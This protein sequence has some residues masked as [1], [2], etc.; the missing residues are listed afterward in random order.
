MTATMIATLLLRTSLVL[1]LALFAQILARKS[2]AWSNAIGRTALVIALGLMFFKVTPPMAVPALVPISFSMP[3][4]S[5]EAPI[6]ASEEPAPTAS[7][8]PGY[9]SV[10]TDEWP[11]RIWLGGSAFI[12]LWTLIGTIRISRM[13]KKCVRV[14][15]PLLSEIAR[16]TGAAEP[17]VL[18]GDCI[19][20]P[21]VAGL[22]RPTIYVPTGWTNT[23]DASCQSAVLTHEAAHIANGDLLWLWV[24][25]ASL[26][27]L[28]P[29]PFVW[30]VCRRIQ[31]ASEELADATVIRLGLDRKS[32]AAC[33]LDH[34]A[35][36][37]KLAP[38]MSLATVGKKSALAS[39]IEAIM[40]GRIRILKLTRTSSAAVGLTM[41]A[42]MFGA[43]TVFGY[44]AQA[45]G[46]YQRGSYAT[47]V[48]V[49]SK[50]KSVPK[51]NQALL[52]VQESFKP[53]QVVELKVNKN[54]V[55]IPRISGDSDR[56]TLLIKYDA[57]FSDIKTIWPST[58]KVVGMQVQGEGK[59]MGR[60]I[61]AQGSAMPLEI[62]PT[63]F[64]RVQEHMLVDAL[65]LPDSI[66]R[67]FVTKID[68]D[69]GFSIK[70]LPGN[71]KVRLQVSDPNYADFGTENDLLATSSSSAS[72]EL[73]LTPGGFI[74]GKIT[75]DGKPVSGVFVGAQ[76]NHSGGPNSG[77]TAWSDAVTDADGNYRIRRL[78]TGI[79]NVALGLVG[80]RSENLTSVA[81][82]SVRVTGGQVLNNIDFSLIQGSELTGTVTSPDGKPVPNIMI[83]CYGP[84]HPNSSA[85]VQNARTDSNGV[86][87]LRVPAG[88][89]LVYC[90]DWESQQ[91]EVTT[92]D[93]KRTRQDIVVTKSRIGN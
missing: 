2:A 77:A 74:T 69:G 38:S 60:L 46:A 24:K 17:A 52:I 30:L 50:G 4:V 15:L 12:L 87:R 6:A 33:L 5:V 47:T 14:T 40:D 78:A 25:R 7:L 90:M 93:G 19:S 27:A 35:A 26:V 32:Y 63:T 42:G 80:E 64:I 3:A 75:Q 58:N 31:R 21:F 62:E 49:S 43:L 84:A 70:G 73:T 56:G 83:G 89:Q 36:L 1:A 61:A 88:K 81:H 28:W 13:R 18:E 54:K 55:T 72:K 23:T 10:S 34:Q 66:R 11:L 76:D 91:Y 29:T 65:V 53:A 9:D 92:E 68:P 41:L 8:P 86:Y 67:T 57:H 45:E 85:W 59:C 16:R 22:F 37:R 71:V 79:Y 51:V 20:T 82:E 44:T 48:T 39:R